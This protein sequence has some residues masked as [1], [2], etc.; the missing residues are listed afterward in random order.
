VSSARQP[1]PRLIVW[2]TLPL[3]IWPIVDLCREYRRRGEDV[4]A[5]VQ[6]VFQHTRPTDLVLDGWLG[7]N[8]FRPSPSYYFFIHSELWAMLTPAQ[9]AAYVDALTSGRAKPALVTL[10]NELRA[11]GPRFLQWLHEN[12]VS[13]DG[14]FYLPR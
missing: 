6:F 11:I 12:Y 4:M 7:T 9:K 13:R 10:D 2:A 1:R 3:L 14:L 5:R 8:V